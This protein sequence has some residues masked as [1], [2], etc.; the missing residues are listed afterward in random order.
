MLGLKLN[1]VSKRG[2]RC[3]LQLFQGLYHEMLLKVIHIIS[4]QQVF[5]LQLV[6]SWDAF[7]CI[8]IAMGFIRNDPI[9]SLEAME[10]VIVIQHDWNNK[11]TGPIKG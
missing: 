2:L 6:S 8:R 7:P 9:S 3:H 4:P 10:I 1:H 11:I 5:V